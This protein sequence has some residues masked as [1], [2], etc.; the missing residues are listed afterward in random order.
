MVA[1]PKNLH[2]SLLDRANSNAGATDAAALQAVVDRARHVED[3]GYRRILVA[4]HHGVPGIPGS[5]PAVL[6]AAVAS[7]TTSIR[8]GTG[9]IM[10]PNH[11]PLIVAEQ[12]ATLEA[13]YP[14]RIDAGIGS[15]VGFTEPVR[16]A[17]RQRDPL[18]SKARYPEDLE[19][20]L[21]FLRGDAAI[22]ARPANGAATPVYLLAGFRSAMLAA[23]NG[24]GVILG[25]PS[26]FDRSLGVHEGLR[27]YREEFVPSAFHGTPHAIVSL[28][29]A[30]ADTEE[31]ARDLLIPEAWAQV[32]ARATGS[33]GPLEP[34]AELDESRLTGRE[35]QRL[36]EL[37]AQS[38]YGTPAQ[39]AVQLRDLQAFTGVDEVLVTGGMSDTEGQRRSDTL[40]AEI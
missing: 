30:V 19:E 18:G 7:A 6:A 35:R 8:V 34:V 22:T 14:G 33:F 25:G 11:Q 21:S 23:R 20:M 12:V 27:R 13:L 26:L 40:L 36:S 16:K 2:F 9:G 10:L 37:L 39:V 38:V 32:K 3:L 31:A 15:S 29:I 17:L 28:N 5:T 1:V 4:E 24:L